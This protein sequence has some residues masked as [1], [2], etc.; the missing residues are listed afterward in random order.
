MVK[1]K[2]VIKRVSRGHT[3]YYYRRGGKQARLP[4]NP[5]SEEFDREYCRLR[6]GA[7]LGSSKRSF[8]VLIQS[9]KNSPAYRSLA[10][11]TQ[12]EYNRTLEF[13][14]E[15]QGSKD[16]T[17]L[18]R[19]HVIEAQTKYA[20]T[21]R[22]ANAIVETISILAKHAIDLEWI[23]VNPASGVKKLK[24]G[25]YE[26][27]PEKL[28]DLFERYVRKTNDTFALTAMK[29]AV[30]SGQRIGDVCAMEWAH[31]DGEYISVVQEKTGARLWVACPDFLKDYLDNL[32]RSGKHILA[33]SLHKPMSKRAIQTRVLNARK[34]IGAEAYQI[35]GWRYNAAMFLA[36][37]GA[38]DSEIQAVTG[39]K[40]LGMVN[41]YRSQAR[42]KTLSKAAQ[43]RRTK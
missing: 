18:R 12:K 19:R 26:A 29:L 34:Q 25:S 16:F 37:S 3:Y 22:K 6:S 21:W 36:E 32:P 9:Y 20:D 4:D 8:E 24:G 27:W 10:P 33:I 11:S 31:Y 35:H 39:H 1:R 7:S 38:T 17:L 28:L 2:Y 30:G 41:K 5:D 43:S 42:Q 14:R 40:T 15:K 23:T 13:L